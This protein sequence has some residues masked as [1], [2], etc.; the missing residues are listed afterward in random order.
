MKLNQ[1]Q[2][3]IDDD[4]HDEDQYDD[5]DNADDDD[6]DDDDEDWYDNDH[7][8]DWYDE[9]KDE[10]EEDDDDIIDDDDDTYFI[11][12]DDTYLIYTSQDAAAG[13]SGDYD[14]VDSKAQFEK[15]SAAR[16]DARRAPILDALPEE[17]WMGGTYLAYMLAI[18][19]SI[20]SYI[21][22]QI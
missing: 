19:L 5:D 18:Y 3:Y 7:D 8:E 21:D 16:K 9:D 6:D 2:R 15:W 20:Y 12:D 10:E 11:D 1:L 17:K 4:G 14:E 13:G 22:L